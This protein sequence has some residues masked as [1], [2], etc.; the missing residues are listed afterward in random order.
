[1]RYF[2]AAGSVSPSMSK[3][4]AHIDA[5]ANFHDGGR[6]SG[7]GWGVFEKTN[8]PRRRRFLLF[9]PV[10]HHKEF[11]QSHPFGCG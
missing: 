4:K 2:H 6:L 9:L 7:F 8:K 3:A 10:I 5:Q 1:M 11:N